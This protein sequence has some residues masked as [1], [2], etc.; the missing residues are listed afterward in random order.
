MEGRLSALVNSEGSGGSGGHSGHTSE[1]P[2]GDMGRKMGE[3]LGLRD[4]RGRE[5]L[6]CRSG[7]SRGGGGLVFCHCDKISDRMDLKEERIIGAHSQQ[8]FGAWSETKHCDS[9]PLTP[10]WPGSKEQQEGATVSN[11]PS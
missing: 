1:R 11:I 7:L 8:S 5:I 3:A 9:R 4:R 10:W 6:V 2:L